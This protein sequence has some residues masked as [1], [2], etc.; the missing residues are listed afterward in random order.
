[1]LSFVVSFVKDSRTA[2][3]PMN[4]ATDACMF[5]VDA[6]P[7]FWGTFPIKRYVHSFVVV[8]LFRGNLCLSV[9][10]KERNV[11]DDEKDELVS[12]V[13]QIEKV[14]DTNESENRE[15]EKNIARKIESFGGDG[16][17]V[18]IIF[19][20]FFSCSSKTSSS[21]QK[22]GVVLWRYKRPPNDGRSVLKV[23]VIITIII[24]RRLPLGTKTD[25][26]C[27]QELEP[28]GRERRRR[29]RF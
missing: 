22:R 25:E 10:R 14:D 5:G 23:D 16:F 8:F 17:I 6:D 2:R 19:F 13:A 18:I 9:E 11:D 26:N 27:P 29:R 7:F 21:K 24:E 15:E 12:V 28:I 3:L 20:F 4:T 1:M